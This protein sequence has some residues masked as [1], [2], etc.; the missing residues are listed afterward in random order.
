M[1]Y[2]DR[3]TA[4]YRLFIQSPFYRVPWYGTCYG[5]C[6]V[7]VIIM[8]QV[9]VA[10]EAFRSNTANIIKAEGPTCD[11]RK[12][13][14]EIHDSL[15]QTGIIQR[16]TILGGSLVQSVNNKLLARTHKQT[17]TATVNTPL[18]QLQLLQLAKTLRA[19][20]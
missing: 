8:I 4:E 18:G 15:K 7:Q 19:S 9:E 14:R 5:K 12:A 1:N 10:W 3:W 11:R 2:D 13:Q 16:T 20:V 17:N 6:L